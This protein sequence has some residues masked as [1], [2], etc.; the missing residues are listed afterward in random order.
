MGKKER[1]GKEFERLVARIE[2]ILGP[3][4]AIVTSP[5]IS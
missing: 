5:T 3:A 4:G 1:A 2:K